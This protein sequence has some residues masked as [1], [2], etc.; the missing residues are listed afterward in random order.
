MAVRPHIL[1]EK[2]CPTDGWDGMGWKTLISSDR[3]PTAG[4]TQGIAELRPAPF[5]RRLIHCHAHAET[6]FVLSGQGVLWIED[7]SHTL[8]PGIAAFIPGGARHATFAC[9]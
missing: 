9:A 5:D 6:Y 7:A 8:Y 4:I 1:D 2:S 3:T